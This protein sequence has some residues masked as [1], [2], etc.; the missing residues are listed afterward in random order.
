MEIRYL[1]PKHTPQPWNLLTE[2]DEDT[3]IVR[4]VIKPGGARNLS[5]V[6]LVTTGS[7]SD[8]VEAANAQLITMCPELLKKAQEHY[9]YL[10]RYMPD[11]L[12]N[13]AEGQA[14]LADARNTIS[15]ASGYSAQEVQEYFEAQAS[16][17]NWPRGEN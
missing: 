8:E 9:L 1:E 10:L 3:C 14:T 12:R 7:F 17:F 16:K 15:D 13:T 4:T 5:E 11:S 6:A 2:G